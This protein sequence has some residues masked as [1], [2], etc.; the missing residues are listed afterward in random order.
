MRK[1]PAAG[2]LKA[3]L[4]ERDLPEIAAAQLSRRME[5]EKIVTARELIAG[6]GF[7]IALGDPE[8]RTAPPV[9]LNE[10]VTPRRRF[11]REIPAKI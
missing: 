2:P 5:A 3:W 11:M 6:G 4:S 10:T 1:L 8:K 9:F 7:G